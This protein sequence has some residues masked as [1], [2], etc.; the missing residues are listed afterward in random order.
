MGVSLSISAISRKRGST[1]NT[2][3]DYTIQPDI[4]RLAMRL[5]KTFASQS[6][7]YR[8]WASWFLG[9]PD[10]ALAEP[11]IKLSAT[12]ERLA[13]LLRCYGALVHTSMAHLILCGDYATA[14]AEAEETVALASEKGVRSGRRLEDL[15]Q[16]CLFGATGKASDAVQTITS[17]IDTLR[18]TGLN[19]VV[20]FHLA[21][22]A[23]G[24]RRSSANLDDA[25]RCIAE[26]VATMVDA[27]KE[28]GAK[29]EFIAIGGEIALMS[30]EPDTDERRRRISSAHS[31]SPANNK[32]N[33]GNSAP[34]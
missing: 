18:S 4:V 14:Y 16:G 20:P 34:P 27:A 30:P 28:V 17:G 22:L 11:Q 29:P 19:V 12:R 26:A 3:C 32:P 1:L 9:Y 5:A 13:T 33:P 24:V 6:C 7:A 8:S 23:Q 31:R 21:C 2:R 25:W 10:A 15:S